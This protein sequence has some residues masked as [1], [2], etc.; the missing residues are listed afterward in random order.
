LKA[1]WF[2]PKLPTPRPEAA[3]PDHFLNQTNENTMTGRIRTIDLLSSTK[4]EKPNFFLLGAGRCGTTTLYTMLRQHPE[5]FMP[6]VKEPSFFCSYFQVIKD[7]ITYFQLFN[8]GN[9]ETA[10]GEASH[11][12]LSNPES[13]AVLHSLFPKAKFI[14]IFRSPTE[15]AYSLYQWARQ[16]GLEPLDTFEEAIEAEAQRYEDPVFFKNCP[17]YFWNFMY[18]RSSYYHL[19]WRRYL[20]FYSPNNFFALS[21]HELTSDPIHWIQRIFEFLGVR[22]NFV[23]SFEHLNSCQYPPLLAATKQRLDNHFRDVISSTESL[24]GRRIGKLN[25]LF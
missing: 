19:Q 9:G 14:L 25:A 12:Y 4:T 3:P 11:V 16:A 18:V 21:L 7:P 20:Q 24:A 13:A 5:I 2:A 15:R 8:P 17:Q 1:Q 6:K 23:P 22:S 10:I